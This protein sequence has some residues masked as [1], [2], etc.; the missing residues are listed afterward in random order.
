MDPMSSIFILGLEDSYTREKLFKICP[1][2][3]K[4]TVDFEELVRAASEIAVAK[5]NCLESENCSICGVSGSSGFSSKKKLCGNCNKRTIMRLGFLRRPGRSIV[6]LIILSVENARRNTI[7]LML[8][9]QQ[10]GS[11]RR[12]TRRLNT[13]L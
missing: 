2:T 1:A 12:T 6:R 3:G 4:S 8:V 7:S 9:R 10:T 13:M 5:D 11:K